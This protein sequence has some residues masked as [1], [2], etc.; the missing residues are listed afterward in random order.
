MSLDSF[1]HKLLLITKN[2]PEAKQL[3]MIFESVGMMNLE[4][5]TA[6]TNIV[7]KLQDRSYIGCIL[8]YNAA[9]K[10]T[11]RVV[12][13][14]RTNTVSSQVPVIVLAPNLDWE[15]VRGLY[16]AGANFVMRGS[17]TEQV[18]DVAWIMDSLIRYATNF[19][20]GMERYH[21]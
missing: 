1:D 4:V 16:E 18:R 14:I 13:N 20:K 10:L 15:I 17:I 19:K 9:D 11:E 12:R 2:Q 3:N 6:E 8:N 7:A 21:R 5:E